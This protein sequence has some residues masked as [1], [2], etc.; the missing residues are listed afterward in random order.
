MISTRHIGN[1]LNALGYRFFSGVPCSS[2]KSLINTALNDMV[3]ISSANEGDAV[4]VSTGAVLGGQKAVVLMQNS[5]LTNAISPLTSLNH[6]FKCPILGFVSLRGEPGTEDEPQHALM[7]EITQNLLDTMKIASQIL[8]PDMDEALV[9]LKKADEVIESGH[10]FFFIVKKGTFDAVS[11]C[12]KP[13]AD[14]RNK[15]KK[16]AERNSDVLARREVLKALI[17]LRS[18]KTVLLATT[19]F[20]GRE[21]YD[22]EDHE[23]HLYMVGSMGCASSLGLGLALTKP[24]HNIVVIDGDGA[25]L[26]RMGAIATNAHYS[27]PNLCHLLIDNGAHDS[28]GGQLTVSNHVNFVDIAAA[29]GYTSSVFAHSIEELK[30]AVSEWHKH[31]GLSFIHIKTEPG[32]TGK[33]GRPVIQP[34]EVAKRLQ[35][36]LS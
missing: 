19:G 24:N 7:G 16:G 28:T 26:M 27:P 2:L 6:I 10:S 29:C 17:E 23:Q 13:V 33:L 36:Y 5:G 9:Q 11:L 1:A 21:L 22:I 25:C 14:V 18:D 30:A 32:R 3:Y 31:K 35:G 12:S 20:T 4:A 15:V 34:P 8:S